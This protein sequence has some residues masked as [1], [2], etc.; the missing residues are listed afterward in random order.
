MLKERKPHIRS[1]SN[2]RSEIT[3]VPFSGIQM[4]DFGFNLN[5]L[6]LRPFRFIERVT[7]EQM[8]KRS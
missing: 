6:E 3:L 4:L 7:G 8:A 1:L 2:L 5:K